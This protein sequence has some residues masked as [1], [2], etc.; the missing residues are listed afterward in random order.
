[1]GLRD[2]FGGGKKASMN[3]DDYEMIL[4]NI[5]ECVIGAYYN[6]RNEDEA[7]PFDMLLEDD[8]L[9]NQEELAEMLP[10]YFSYDEEDED[11]NH[12]VMFIPPEMSG[13]KTLDR[14]D[15]KNEFG[16]IM[17]VAQ[18]AS[19]CIHEIYER[20]GALEEGSVFLGSELRTQNIQPEA[21]LVPDSNVVF[22]HCELA[23]KYG[24]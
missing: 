13:I 10:E 5:Y 2:L 20:A 17:G 22:L 9:G 1:M 24:L 4:M 18:K 19:S 6:N 21:I 15:L 11:N 23:L 14:D 8:P 7:W 12:G 16:L 3:E